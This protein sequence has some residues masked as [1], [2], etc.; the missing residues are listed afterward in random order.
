M[1]ILCAVVDNVIFYSTT[2]HKNSKGCYKR[3]NDH[4][5]YQCSHHVKSLRIMMVLQEVEDSITFHFC[6]D[7]LTVMMPSCSL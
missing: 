1:I 2:I 4:L 7:C 5:A 6:K 3:E